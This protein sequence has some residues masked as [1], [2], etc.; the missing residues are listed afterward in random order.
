M[1]VAY[2]QSTNLADMFNSA[3]TIAR[4]YQTQNLGAGSLLAGFA[5]W[6]SATDTITG[7]SDSAGN[8]WT[9]V[10]SSLIQA[11]GYSLQGFY[12]ANAAGSGTKPTVTVTFSA[13]QTNKGIILYEFSGAHTTAPL[14]GQVATN[15]GSVGGGTD[16]VSSGNW[17][18]STN[19]DML[20]GAMMSAGFSGSTITAGTS[21]EAYTVD[22][23]QNA[24]SQSFAAEHATQATASA[25]TLTKFSTSGFTSSVLLSALAFKVAAGGAAVAV[26][27]PRGM[28]M[29]LG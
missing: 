18:T 14:D 5:F 25:S 29:G 24:N 12:M 8:T 28:S 15:V 4:A 19:G 27:W 22:E 20:V 6:S 17:T 13:A 10:G 9:V 7:V 2:V 1:A 3:N 21:S 16:T 23:F 11:S 26:Y